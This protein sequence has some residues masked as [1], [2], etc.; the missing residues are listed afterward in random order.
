MLNRAKALKDV[1]SGNGGGAHTASRSLLGAP[2]RCT[3]GL[4]WVKPY[5]LMDERR[6]RSWRR[7]LLGGAAFGGPTWM[8]SG[9]GWLVV[10]PAR[11][12]R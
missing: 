3:V 8:C 5:P 12:G 11:G 9:G 2:L 4:S 6:W 7:A 10:L 1:V